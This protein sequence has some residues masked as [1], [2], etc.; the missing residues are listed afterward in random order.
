ME[1]ACEETIETV[2]VA[3]SRGGMPSITVFELDDWFMALPSKTK[4][5]GTARPSPQR[6]PWLLCHQV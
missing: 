5:R 2:V 4:S 1:V 3:E 6:Q